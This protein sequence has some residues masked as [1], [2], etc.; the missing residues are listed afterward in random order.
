MTQE[1]CKAGVRPVHSSHIPALGLLLIKA[2]NT[3]IES[4]TFTYLEK[5]PFSNRHGVYL[6]CVYGILLL[7]I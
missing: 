5:D 1:T 7:L 3:T 2:Q 6:L 4:H